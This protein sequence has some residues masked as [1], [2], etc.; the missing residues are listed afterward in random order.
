MNTFIMQTF[1]M[2]PFE[3]EH[4]PI[5]KFILR[6]INPSQLDKNFI[7]NDIQEL[8]LNNLVKDLNEQNDTLSKVTTSLENMGVSKAKLKAFDTIVINDDLSIRLFVSPVGATKQPYS[9][10]RKHYCWFCRHPIPLEWHPVGIPLKHKLDG[11]YK[12][13]T[14]DCEGIFCSFNCC[15]A[16]LNEHHEYRFKDSTVLLLMMYRKLFKQYKTITSI[17][18]SPSWKLLKEYGGHLTIEEYRKSLQH[19]DYRS[20][21]QIMYRNDIKINPGA[22]QFV[23]AS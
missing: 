9:E 20:M 7:M 1:F 23:E 14:F 3:D 6:S 21:Q 17:L 8:G 22:E 15:M 13:D 4:E 18:P 2:A 5:T 12:Q 11:Q 10:L 16:Y 19:V